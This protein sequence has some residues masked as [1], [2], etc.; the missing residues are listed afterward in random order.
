ML[1]KEESDSMG[2]SFEGK[3]TKEKRGGGE[4][5]NGNEEEDSARGKPTFGNFVFV[6]VFVC[7]IMFQSMIILTFIYF[8][9]Y[10]MI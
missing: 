7:P 8:Y 1:S 10:R 6:C 3:I 5:E 2:S 4:E 9:L